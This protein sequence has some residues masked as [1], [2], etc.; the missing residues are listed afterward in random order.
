MVRYLYCTGTVL[1]PKGPETGKAGYA[2]NRCVARESSHGSRSLGQ[3]M[4]KR[5]RKVQLKFTRTYSIET[6]TVYCV[7][8]YYSVERVSG[9]GAFPSESDL[10][11]MSQLSHAS[12]LQ[13]GG[14]ALPI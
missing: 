8:I 4:D 10:S 12:G 5:K 14:P 11:L 9:K 2:L 3:H 6:Y 13:L 1:G 7:I